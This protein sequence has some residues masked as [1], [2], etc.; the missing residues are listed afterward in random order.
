MLF[1]SQVLTSLENERY[2]L[3]SVIVGAVSDFLLNLIFI[4]KYGAAGAALATTIA[5]FLVLFVQMYYTRGLLKEVNKDI[6]AINY[7][8][9]CLISGLGAYPVKLL[10]VNVFFKLIISV[11]VFFGIYGAALLITKEPIVVDAVIG[12][13]EKIEKG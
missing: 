12:L 1:R 9:I 11:T 13:K 10:G 2:V 6:R 5:E 7:L 4:P 8:F 3:H